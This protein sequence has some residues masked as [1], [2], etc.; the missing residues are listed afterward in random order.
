[1]ELSRISGAA[2][3]EEAAA[4]IVD[5]GSK[6]HRFWVGLVAGLRLLRNPRDTQQVFVLA[7]AVD[8]SKLHL[9]LAHLRELPEGRALLGDRP[10][11]DSKSVDFA[12][13]RALPPHT[14]GGA[15]ARTL[16]REQLD[17]DLFRPPPLLSPELTF[18]VQRIRQTHDIWHVVTG[19]STSI[20]DEIALQ[21]FTN[22]QLHNHTSRLIMTFGAL[23][24]GLRSATLRRKVRAFR[25]V[26]SGCAFLL[27]VRWEELWE[28][29]LDQVRA[30][31][32]VLL[33]LT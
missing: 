22:A 32:D 12:R 4:R 1:M 26:G 30:R 18:V 7:T 28:V 16:E 25:R 2:L 23:F 31:L 15:Y 17:P 5:S 14:L 20:E 33:P 29:P 3:Q 8:R 11:I 24:Y 27:A 6:L 9:L 10:A 21:A 13:L 19:L